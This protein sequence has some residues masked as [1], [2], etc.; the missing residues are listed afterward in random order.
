MPLRLSLPLPPTDNDIYVPVKKRGKSAGMRLSDTA[1]A[2]KVKVA[3]LMADAAV[4]QPDFVVEDDVEYS[5]TLVVF[6][7]AAYSK[8]WPKRAKC[9]FRKIDS[10]NRLKLVIDAVMQGL[11]LDD[12]CLFEQSITKQEDPEDPRIEVEIRRWEWA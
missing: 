7:K 9:R 3:E 2:Y 12:N 11:G 8:D 4:L 1:R 6:F 10:H 5:I